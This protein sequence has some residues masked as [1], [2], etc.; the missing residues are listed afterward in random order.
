MADNGSNK[1]D[2]E[3]DE[4]LILALA[5]GRDVRDVAKQTGVSERTIY[6][7]LKDT[8][9]RHRISE[10]RAQFTDKALGRLSNA[11]TKA[12]D[13]LV[14]L[15]DADSETVRLRASTAILELESFIESCA[16]FARMF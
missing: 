12:V 16:P 3:G 10:V 14:A 1:T 11:A 5:S 13:N 6:R 2:F 4:P 8:T 7:R 9:F 15:L